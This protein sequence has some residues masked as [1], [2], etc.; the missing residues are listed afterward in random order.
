MASAGVWG[1]GGAEGCF[2]AVLVAVFRVPWGPVF[3]DV[4]LCDE[5][6]SGSVGEGCGGSPGG[7]RVGVVS[8]PLREHGEYSGDGD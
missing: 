1:L 7:F 4:V 2:Q 3:A 6:L 8:E 5:F